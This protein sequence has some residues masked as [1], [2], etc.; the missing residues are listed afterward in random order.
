MSRYQNLHFAKSWFEILLKLICW[1]IS[2]IVIYKYQPSKV[3]SEIA[4]DTTLYDKS[5]AVSMF[6]F[7]LSCGCDFLITIL[8]KNKGWARLIHI[9]LLAAIVYVGIYCFGIITDHIQGTYFIYNYIIFIAIGILMFL[10]IPY[11]ELEPETCDGKSGKNWGHTSQRQSSFKRSLKG[12][13]K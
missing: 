10:D 6:I 1:A 13:R 5:S 3:A 12:Y 4:I 9:L 7:A 11:I 2:L 8:N